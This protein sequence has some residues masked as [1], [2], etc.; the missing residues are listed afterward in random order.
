MFDH[1][2]DWNN[3]LSNFEVNK[4]YDF[5]I[6]NRDVSLYSLQIYHRVKDEQL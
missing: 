2:L 1:K 5:K 6:V 4:N 3:V